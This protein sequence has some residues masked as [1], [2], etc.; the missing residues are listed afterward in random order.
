MEL[1]D[2]KEGDVV[3]I[4]A[5]NWHPEKLAKIDRITKTQI[6]VGELKFNKNTGYMVGTDVW[7]RRY[8]YIPNEEDI[9]RITTSKRR[10]DLLNYVKNN[11]ESCS[12]GQLEEIYGIMK[13][14]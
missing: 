10:F 14:N 4:S 3:M 5:S 9:K 12:V 8:L 7:N 1:K 6:V 2:L 11:I 13:K